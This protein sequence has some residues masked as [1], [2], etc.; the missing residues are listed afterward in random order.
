MEIEELFQLLAPNCKPFSLLGFFSSSVTFANKA[1]LQFEVIEPLEK[2][3][4]V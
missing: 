3:K 1:T 2:I 4:M